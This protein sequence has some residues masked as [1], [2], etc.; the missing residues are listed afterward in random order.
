MDINIKISKLLK[1]GIIIT[2]EI[3]EGRHF[4]QI[5]RGGAIVQSTKLYSEK[6]KLN[7]AIKKAIDYEFNKIKER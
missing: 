6:N 2:P 1:K 7:A 4:I 5:N 3:K